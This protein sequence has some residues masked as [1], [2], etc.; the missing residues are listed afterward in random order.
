MLRLVAELDEFKGEWKALGKLA[1]D[2]LKALKK[3]QQSNQSDRQ[4]GLKASKLRIGKWNSFFPVLI[5]DFSDH[6]MKKRW[7]AMPRR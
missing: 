6:A 2:R 5:P 3:L 1:P 7:L 4:L